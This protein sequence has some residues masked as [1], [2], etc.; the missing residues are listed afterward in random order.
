VAEQFK[1]FHRVEFEKEMWTRLRRCGGGWMK[2]ITYD[3]IREGG[4]TKEHI[5]SVSTKNKSVDIIIFSSLLRD[6]QYSRAKGMDAVRVV[7]RWKTKH[8]SLYK[9]VHKHLRVHTLFENLISTIISTQ[10]DVF[11]L[12]P[13]EFTRSVE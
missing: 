2:D 5:Y 1:A 4:F 13:K 3:Y 10:K 12:N 7:L 9:R 11:N 8:G 6:G